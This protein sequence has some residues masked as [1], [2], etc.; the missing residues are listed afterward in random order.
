[1]C[2]NLQ[3]QNKTSYVKSAEEADGNRLDCVW[4]ALRRSPIN[5]CRRGKI[6]RG[7]VGN[8]SGKRTENNTWRQSCGHLRAAGAFRRAIVFS[9][10][11]STGFGS[12]YFE[13]TTRDKCAKTGQLQR[14]KQ[15]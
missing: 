3:H 7:T 5:G 6:D 11:E 1:M 14:L 13:N 15:A 9:E 4:I 10:L 8:L 12:F 2:Y